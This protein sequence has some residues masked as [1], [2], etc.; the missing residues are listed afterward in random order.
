MKVFSVILVKLKPHH[1]A[2]TSIKYIRMYVYYNR[3]RNNYS[4]AYYSLMKLYAVVNWL[5]SKPEA[6][7]HSH[8]P[9]ESTIT[10]LRRPMNH[11]SV[12]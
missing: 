12:L 10:S 6:A 1:A 3:I 7:Q 5:A 8:K 4:K 9:P 11:A 2:I